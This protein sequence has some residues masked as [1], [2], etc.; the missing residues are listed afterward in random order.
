[1]MPIIIAVLKQEQLLIH[2]VRQKQ[3]VQEIVG[4]Q[5]NAL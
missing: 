1:M 2:A 5:A 3:V 4:M